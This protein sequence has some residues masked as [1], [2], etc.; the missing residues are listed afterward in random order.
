MRIGFGY[1]IH[2]L[3]PD[4]ALV[5]GGVSIPFEKGLLGHSDAD[6]L[7]HAIADALLGAAAIGDIGEHFP[8]TDEAYQDISSKELL[9]K[10]VEILKKDKWHINNIDIMVELEE[11]KL[12]PFKDK[13]RGSIAE[14]AGI[15]KKRVNIKA[16]TTELVGP[17]GRGEA[18]ASQAVVL[19][20]KR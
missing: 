2:A 3:V 13:M 14:V 11:P 8:N 20:Q 4:R 9:H 19:I 6:V 12:E 15:E 16:T 5:L 7:C 18:A 10:V 1:D 17:I